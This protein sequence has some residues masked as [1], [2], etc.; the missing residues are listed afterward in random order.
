MKWPCGHQKGS[1]VAIF[2]F[3]VSIP[4]VSRCL[5]AFRMIFVQNNRF[6]IF[7]HW[8]IMERSQN[9]PNLCSLIS[10]FWGIHFIDTYLYQSLKVS[11]QLFGRCSFASIQTFMRWGHLTC[12]GNLTLRDMGL[13]FSKH[14]R[15]RCLIRLKKA[16]ALRAAVFWQS[17]KNRKGVLKSPHHGEC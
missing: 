13:N 9:W 12:P 14:M 8:L 4:P 3:S 7:S 16:V 6:S 17:E 15:K 1:L 10:K 2:S 11:R 5:R